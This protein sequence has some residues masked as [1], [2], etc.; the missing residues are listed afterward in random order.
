MQKHS[1]T[2]IFGSIPT[3][4]DEDSA[5]REGRIRQFHND[6]ECRVLIANPQACGEGISLHKA[7]HHAIYLD[8]NFNAAHYLQS[9]DRIHRLGLSKDTLTE[10]TYLISS[11]TIDGII[12]KRLSEKTERMADVLNDTSLKKLALDPY[13]IKIDES[14]GLENQDVDELLAHLSG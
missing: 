2:T 13:D 14:L 3:G 4:D 8:R 10:I 5:T 7:C 9:V 1:P 12:M 6:P 11:D